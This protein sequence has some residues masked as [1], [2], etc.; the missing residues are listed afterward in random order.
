[1]IQRLGVSTSEFSEIR[2]LTEIAT[3]NQQ[4]NY[5]P[6]TRIT[7]SQTLRILNFMGLSGQFLYETRKSMNLNQENC[8]PRA[9]Y[10]VWTMWCFDSFSPDW[11]VNH[12]SV[13]SHR[14]QGNET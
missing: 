10:V 7:L 11:R 6:G 3:F 2:G 5:R 8:S 14:M 4:D 1:M 13:Y 12:Q 9:D